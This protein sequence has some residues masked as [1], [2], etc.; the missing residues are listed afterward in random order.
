MAYPSTQPY[1]QEPI[2]GSLRGIRSRSA[3]DPCLAGTFILWQKR[4]AGIRFIYELS[5]RSRPGY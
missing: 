4:E 1:G 2:Q 5:L 3:D